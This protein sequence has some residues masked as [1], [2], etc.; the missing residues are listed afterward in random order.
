[1]ALAALGYFMES[2]GDLFFPGN[3]DWLVLVVGCFAA[4]GEVSLTLYLLIKGRKP[5]TTG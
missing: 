5:A 1:M 2:F 4:V 3:E